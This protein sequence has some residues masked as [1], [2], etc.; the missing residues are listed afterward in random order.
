M[1]KGWLDAAGKTHEQVYDVAWSGGPTPRWTTFDAKLLGV[2]LPKDVPATTFA[3]G[4]SQQR[5]VSR[6]HIG[7]WQ[8]G[9]LSNLRPS[10]TALT[11]AGRRSDDADPGR[12]P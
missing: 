4:S 5:E 9:Q 12:A 10:A 11:A 1:I 8:I 2:E 6:F 7:S 3:T